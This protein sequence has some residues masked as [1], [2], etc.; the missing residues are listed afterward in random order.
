M[1]KAS[2]MRLLRVLASSQVE[3]K[4]NV[5]LR[6]TSAGVKIY[7]ITKKHTPPLGVAEKKLFPNFLLPPSGGVEE[8]QNTKIEI[9]SEP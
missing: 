9:V 1:T 3:V 2:M 8:T 6:M 5:S 4:R 7:N